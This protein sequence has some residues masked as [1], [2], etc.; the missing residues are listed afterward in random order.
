MKAREFLSLVGM[1]IRSGDIHVAED[2]FQLV[3]ERIHDMWEKCPEF[4]IGD[5]VLSADKTYFGI[6][7]EIDWRVEAD[8]YQQ[9]CWHIEWHKWQENIEPPFRD[10]EYATRPPTPLSREDCKRK[11]PTSLVWKEVK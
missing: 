2:D 7:F 11:F 3:M 4:E 5:F 8:V 6:V 9:F 10:I 1:F